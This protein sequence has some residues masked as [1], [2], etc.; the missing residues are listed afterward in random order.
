MVWTLSYEF[1]EVT[2][3]N[4]SSKTL[5]AIPTVNWTNSQ[6]ADS[7]C[8]FQIWLKACGEFVV[9]MSLED[10]AFKA[11]KG[12]RAKVLTWN[13]LAMRAVD[14]ISILVTFAYSA[15]VGR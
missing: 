5:A 15:W 12:V 2:E 1:V 8:S 10:S 13:N 7:K 11:L 9:H 4:T 3:L 6:L 14:L